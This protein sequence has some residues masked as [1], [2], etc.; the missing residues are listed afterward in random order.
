VQRVGYRD[1]V[2][3][4]ARKLKL[5]GFVEDSKPYDIRIIAEG[6][7]DV[8]NEFVNQ[9]RITQHPISPISVEGLDVEFGAA[10]GD[11]EYFEIRR[12]D[13]KDELGER[14]DT[15]GALMYRSVELAVRMNDA[16]DTLSQAT[17]KSSDIATLN[18][19]LGG[20]IREQISTLRQETMKFGEDS[21]TMRRE[22]VE[23]VG[24]QIST[25]RQERLLSFE[26]EML[27]DMHENFKRYDSV[28]QK[29]LERFP[30]EKSVLS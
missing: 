18:E 16:V 4:I 30:Y 9:I 25:L 28:L 27:S 8:L 3:Q 20:E 23:E 6:E 7:E 13:W 29:T 19:E 5:T 22:L 24:E 12:H 21:G 15:A 1:V 2:E 17:A 26:K 14:F 11:F 10:S